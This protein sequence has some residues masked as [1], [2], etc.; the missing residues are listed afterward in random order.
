MGTELIAKN[1][2]QLSYIIGTY[3]PN[4]PS[5]YRGF[6]H[7]TSFSAKN[8]IV[9]SDNSLS[10]FLTRANKFLDKN[11]GYHINEPYKYACA[12]LYHN[13]RI[14]STFYNKLKLIKL[15]KLPKDNIPW[16]LSFCVNGNSQYMKERY[17]PADG[18]IIKVNA[19]LKTD[20]EDLVKISEQIECVEW[21]E[22]KYSTKDIVSD[23]E[24]TLLE[25]YNLYKI[26]K[27][28]NKN[29]L[30]KEIVYLVLTK[31]S[32]VYKGLSYEY[33]EEVRL[34]I[35]INNKFLQCKNDKGLELFIDKKTKR[36]CLKA[37]SS[38]FLDASQKTDILEDK[39]LNLWYIKF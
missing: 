33:E 12:R 24:R 17:A 18:W 9:D 7:Y 34:I 23:L 15:N 10:F 20:L 13:G 11:E 2:L 32:Y 22:I 30:L 14:D 3:Q 19:T 39:K 5:S 35:Y 27:S 36:L 37:N 8:R 16:I 6:Y 1:L 29:K 31:F 4:N 28:V 25:V 21:F 26:E 38:Y